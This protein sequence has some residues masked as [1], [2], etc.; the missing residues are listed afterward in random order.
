MKKK[1]VFFSVI[2]VVCMALISSCEKENKTL[3]EIQ[4]SPVVVPEIPVTIGQTYA[5]GIVFFVDSTGKHGLIAAR[6]N[7][8]HTLPWSN[9]SNIITHAQGIN[10][11]T[12]RENTSAIVYF[13]GSGSYAASICDKLMVSGYSDWYL[14]SKDELHLL[15]AAKAEGWISA[16]LDNAFYWSSTEASESGAW[17]QSFS[18][19]ANSSTAKNGEYSVRAIRSF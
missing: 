6:N 4:P 9:G 2:T 15:Y 7:Q 5:G 18:N 14:P 11:G 19:G 17:S 8:S 13:Q 12:G 10:L 1:I 3:T 16:G